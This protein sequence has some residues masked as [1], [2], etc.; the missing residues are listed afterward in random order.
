M[1][2]STDFLILNCRF[3]GNE[4]NIQQ[5]LSYLELEKFGEELA[6]NFRTYSGIVSFAERFITTLDQSEDPR[7]EIEVADFETLAR[8]FDRIE[9]V[10][11][12][13]VLNII[14]K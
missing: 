6:I 7:N 3:H 14:Q 5:I 10:T 11:M 2:Q 8:H 1:E 12:K 9:S 13:N 4:E